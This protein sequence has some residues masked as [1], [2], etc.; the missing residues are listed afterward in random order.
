MSCCA[1]RSFGSAPY[2]T[3]EVTSR[4]FIELL[5]VA[6]LAG[7][8][9]AKGA[10]DPALEPRDVAL[11]DGMA[12]PET[13]TPSGVEL[14]FDATDNNCNG[15]VDE[16]CGIH[17]GILQFVAKWDD[18]QADV[19]LE[20][21]DVN[22]DIAEVHSATSAGLYKERNCPEDPLCQYA[23]LENV[24]LVGAEPEPGRYRVAVRLN[25]LGGAIPPLRVHLG[26]RVGQRSYSLAFDLSP[27]AKTSERAFEFTL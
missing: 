19:E 10:V 9:E 4:R 26:V 12:L 23:P 24:Y 2:R 16:G 18:P 20:V 15:L 6:G 1:S 11:P 17:S 3:N 8:L 27:G 7:C 21:T 25:R 22:G 5:L 13:C 14:C